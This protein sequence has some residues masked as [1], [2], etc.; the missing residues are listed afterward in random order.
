MLFKA[1][2]QAPF[3]RI[4]L[5]YMAGIIIQYN[6][7]ISSWSSYLF[8][9][10]L[11]LLFFFY[12]SKAGKRYDWVALFG[13]GI[14]LLSFVCGTYLTKKTWDKSE[15]NIQ[16]FHAYLVRVIEE[17]ESKAKTRMCK[18]AILSADSSIKKEA[19]GKQAIIYLPKDSLSAVIVPG[20][21]LHIRAVLEKP[22]PLP[23]E[24]SFDY[25]LYLRKQN[26]S[27]T[28][29]VRGKDWR[30]AEPVPLSG[31][32]W[33]QFRS[34]E[35]RR[36]LFS[37]LR[38][39]LP[40]SQSFSVAA[41]LMF[42]YKNELD[43]DLKQSFSNIGAGHIL[44]V[45]GLHFNLI[46]GIA[47]F[48]L[49]FIGMSKRGRIVKQLILLPVI[50][51]FAFITGLS[52]S[53][54]RAACMLSLWGI[55]SAFFY[56]SFSLNTLAAIAFFMLLYNPFYLFDIGFQLSFLAVLS[57]LI[58]NPLLIHLYTSENKIIQYLWELVAVSF[59]AQIGVLP[60]SLYY[61]HQFPVLFLVTN[62]CL[63]PL[64][65]ILM[66]LIPLSLLLHGLIGNYE[67]LFIPLR[68]L[69]DS[70][71]MIIESLDNIP[72][73]TISQVYLSV[74]TTLF[75]YLALAC[76]VYLFVRKKSFD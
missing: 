48:L 29:F 50:W 34:Y 18:V 4:A 41:A 32:Q 71:V 11:A 51:G 65:G 33:I 59:S 69:M 5:F 55:G 24:D 12:F 39:I 25:P 76:L 8:A 72:G 22:L 26:C 31:S 47:Y 14:L 23:D 57:I 27:A 15:W 70:F 42:G 61:F 19:T 9:S 38:I 63:I 73:G 54:I 37:H 40:D 46:F 62:I 53:V 17:P 21:C 49:S 10:A 13:Y 20:D 67:W 44:A 43:K 3:L 1:F 45:S 68:F 75:L 66:A 7:D 56:K 60:L 30:S 16:G 6:Y 36:N 58:I 52:P 2:R 35:I 74:T 28:G 64:S